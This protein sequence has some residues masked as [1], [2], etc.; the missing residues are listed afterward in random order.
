M[1]PKKYDEKIRYQRKAS[2]CQVSTYNTTYIS[3]QPF[4]KTIS[5]TK[6]LPKCYLGGIL[7]FNSSHYVYLALQRVGETRKTS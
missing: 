1:P 4:V 6:I 2:F 7:I 3:L 5:T